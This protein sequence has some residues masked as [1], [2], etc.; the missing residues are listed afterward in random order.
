[1]LG[2]FLGRDHRAG[3]RAQASDQIVHEAVGSLDL[4]RHRAD[5]AHQLGPDAR[6]C[7][8]LLELGD[9][10]AGR[11]AQ[12]THR[13]PLAG[14]K[15][16]AGAQRRAQYRA[17]GPVAG[18]DAPACRLECLQVRKY[19]VGQPDRIGGRVRSFHQ[20]AFDVADAVV[21]GHGGGEAALRLR[22]GSLGVDVGE[23]CLGRLVLAQDRLGQGVTL[24]KIGGLQPCHGIRHLAAV[25]LL[26]P[27]DDGLGIVERL[28]RGLRLAAI[29]PDQVAGEQQGAIGLDE[30][31]Q[32]H[33][34][35]HLAPGLCGQ[36]GQRADPWNAE[37]GHGGDEVILDR[38]GEE[39]HRHHP[40]QGGVRA[41]HDW[42][43]RRCRFIL[44][45][46]LRRYD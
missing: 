4:G 16:L 30:V 21:P 17:L 40:G 33:I 26:D 11:A 12:L 3:A 31:G 24:G 8:K 20:R 7:S 36:I 39:L 9:A 32:A 10:G 45:R 41:P 2:P 27:R 38:G 29:A 23:F 25:R 37:A 42:M 19:R 46:S 34:G 14:F 22:L 44:S 1:M 15:R 35:A 18:A 28:D 5:L 6:A 13:T 43:L